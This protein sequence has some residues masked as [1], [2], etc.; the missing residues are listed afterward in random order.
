[1][2]C[3]VLNGQASKADEAELLVWRRKSFN[4]ERHYRSLV[5]LLDQISDTV[6]EEDMDP[7]PLIEDLLTKRRYPEERR[8]GPSRGWW[9]VAATT[10]AAAIALF[11]VLTPGSRPEEA[12]FG[13]GEVVTGPLESTTVRLGD[14][15]VVRL[16][17]E[18]RLRVTADQGTRE[19]WM[20]GR[21]Y[22]SV[23]RD[24]SRPFR[25]RTHA[26]D[27]VVLG[28]RFDLEARQDDMRILVVEG[29]V[30]MGA[31]GSQMEITAREIGTV[32]DG[33]APQRRALEVEELERELA[34]VGNFIAFENTPLSQAADELSRRFGVPVVVLDST[35]ARE[36][37][38][39]T[40][41][42]ES[43]EEITR[44]LCR[45]VSVHC[46]IQDGKVTIGL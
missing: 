44:V 30:K 28:T 24:E 2:I 25:V 37:V 10:A 29:A 22:F 26:G 19:V 13:A 15:S 31:P 42:D 1:M 14:G 36:T 45:A 9:Q 43:L 17:P 35:L 4:N 7:P 8:V 46:S 27:A 41:T 40:F 18:S 32:G 3:R 12:A 21:A 5:E 11:V 39:A 38:R 33:G 23:A 34:W 6:L 16:G 20:E